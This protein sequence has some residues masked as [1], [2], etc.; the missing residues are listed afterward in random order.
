MKNILTVCIFLFLT[1]SLHS[2][3]EHNSTDSKYD[4][5]KYSYTG[6][7]YLDSI[8][9]TASRN[10]FDVKDFIDMVRN[11][12]SLYKAFKNL[13]FSE[14]DFENRII[15]FNKKHHPK[16]KYSSINHQHYNSNCRWMEI[17]EEKENNNFY[18][19]NKKYKYYTAKLYDR[20]FYT[21]D[22]ICN[23]EYSSSYKPKDN[24]DSR[25]EK[26][27]K[28]LKKLIFNPGQK[29]N[30]PFI[31]DKTE[32]FSP[33]MRKYYDFSISQEI[34][35]HSDSCYV[36]TAK[37][38]QNISNSDKNKTV[39]RYL[40]TYFLKDNFQILFREYRLKY[41]TLAYNFDIKMKI[42]LTKINNNFLPS[43]IKYDGSW[44]V[45]FKKR[46]T[47]KFETKIYNI[48]PHIPSL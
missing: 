15:F 28:E 17:L 37:L 45:V 33:E 46:E 32:I 5:I 8:V 20:L 24:T 42:N 3:E 23:E 43:S 38:K 34:F 40:K 6:Y 36:F 44:H 30:I 26:Y 21:S 9:V 48:V 47:C 19:R 4:S 35:N 14:Y 12:N 39:L 11:D 22:T 27:I 16:S 2:Q 25:M 18:K 7:I 31:G 13:H 29:A 41:K 1:L 10:G